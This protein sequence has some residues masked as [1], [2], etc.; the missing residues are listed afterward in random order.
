MCFT[1]EI[2]E[3]EEGLLTREEE[4]FAKNY[5]SSLEGH[6]RTLALGHMPMGDFGQ[7]PKE[8]SGQSDANLSAAV[9][10]R[11]ERDIGGVLLEDETMQNKD[12]EVDMTEGSQHL[13]KFRNVIDLVKDGSVSLI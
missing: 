12:A 4:T 11:A 13:L 10:V 2:T 1:K 7:M 6:L 8:M 3:P 5:R 9:F